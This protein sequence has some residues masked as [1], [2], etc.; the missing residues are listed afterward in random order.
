MGW[1]KA[2]AAKDMNGYLGSYGKEFNPPGDLSRKAWEE[3]RR[4]R[5]LGKSSISVKVS[6]LNVAMHGNTATAKF[7]QDYS[8][9]SVTASVNKTLELVKSGDR[10]LIV[11]ERTG[12]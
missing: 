2:W 4:A 7:R 10:W 6:N 5:I 11:K 3:E 12:S 1:A 8:G 9:G